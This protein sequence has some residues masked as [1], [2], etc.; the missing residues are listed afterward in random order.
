MVAAEDRKMTQEMYKDG[1]C[2]SGM[3][4]MFMGQKVSLTLLTREGWKTMLEEA[5]LEI[6]DTEFHV[7]EPPAKAMSDLEP[8]YFII[9]RKLR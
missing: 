3:Q 7:F 5:G 1:L 9:A 6:V 4:F 8:H 2:A